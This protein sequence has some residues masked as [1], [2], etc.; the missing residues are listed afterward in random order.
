MQSLSTWR[1]RLR[2]EAGETPVSLILIAP[3]IGLIL[4]AIFGAG[5]LAEAQTAVETAAGSAVREVTLATTPG[6]GAAAAREVVA[7]TLSQ[8]G[9]T[10]PPTVTV[11]AGA[12][13]NAPGVGGEA[14]VTVQ[15]SVQLGDLM[16][17]GLPGT[18]QI[19]RQVSSPVDTYRD[20]M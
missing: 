9:I 2:Q 4:M 7:S 12:L 14:T 13:L 19:E 6:N 1:D 11:D 5:R 3:T 20:R 10:C 18:I 8:R 16:V 15:C 17:P